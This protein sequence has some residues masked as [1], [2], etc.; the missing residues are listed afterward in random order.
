MKLG[1]ILVLFGDFFLEQK[2][3]VDLNSRQMIKKVEEFG[4]PG[5]GK[6]EAK[7]RWNYC[8][9]YGDDTPIGLSFSRKD[10][11]NLKSLRSK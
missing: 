9:T 11:K 6:K 5:S 8:Q 4:F 3:F 2:V 7:E 10:K 1:L